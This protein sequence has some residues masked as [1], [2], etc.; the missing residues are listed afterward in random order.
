MMEVVLVFEGSRRVL[1]V[2]KEKSLLTEIEKD[3]LKRFPERDVVVAAV[4][5]RVLQSSSKEVHI[6]QK[7]TEKWGFV[8]VT[9][10]SQVNSGDELTLTKIARKGEAGLHVSGHLIEPACM[11]VCIRNRWA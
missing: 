1:T 4:G 5:E 8:D 10:T 6:L 3:I 2:P 11:P 7:R 9:D